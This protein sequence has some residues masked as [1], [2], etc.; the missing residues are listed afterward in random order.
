MEATMATGLTIPDTVVLANLFSDIQA[1]KD[2]QQQQKDSEARVNEETQSTSHGSHG[3]EA[4][5]K[6]LTSYNNRND[7]NFTPTVFTTW[8]DKDISPLLNKYLVQPYTR[9]GQKIVRHPTDVVFLTHLIIIFITVVPSAI[10]LYIINFNYFHAV[11]HTCWA[12]FCMGPFTLLMHNHI[13]NNGVLSK[14]FWWLDAAF[15]YILE[16][17]MGHSW[18]SYYYHHVKHHHVEG[19]NPDDLSSTVRYQRD[20][21]Y[22]FLC[23]VARFCFFISLE[24]PIY[25]VRKGKFARAFKAAVSEYGSYAMFYF[26]AKV[27]FRAT[28]FVMLI[29]FSLLR[30]AM[31]VGNFGQH[32]LVDE[33]EPD[34][35]FR[36]SITLI[37]VPVSR[38]SRGCKVTR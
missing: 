10:Y 33:I 3:D 31:M 9:I 11:L 38:Y 16:P 21:P 32:A 15:P 25:F 34:S 7:S 27:N 2:K 26:M 8:D 6:L 35:D 13:H 18:D 28:L 37:D 24:L 23:Y 19:N 1:W 14:Q 12:G 29:P 5:I 30:F 4:D 36:S 22:D 20:E 17:L